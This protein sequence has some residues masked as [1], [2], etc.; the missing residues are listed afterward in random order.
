MIFDAPVLLALAPLVGLLVGGLAWLARRRRIRRA[1]AWSPELAEAALRTSRLGPVLLGGAALAATVALAGPRG[2]RTTVKAETRALSV[3]LAMDISRS[4]LAEDTRPSR[5]ARAVREARRLVQDLRDD[6]IGLV[7]FAGRSYILAPLTLDG[8]AITLFLD[9][10]SPDLASQGGTGLA[11]ALAQGAGVLN[12]SREAGD[13]VLV[14]FTDGEAHDSLAD[15]LAQARLV[16]AAGIRLVLVAEGGPRP[17]PIP[18]RD[19]TGAIAEYKTDERGAIVE[20][21]RRDD[22]LQAVADAA[23]AAL[24]P[25]ELP[26]QAG[27]VRDLLAA[28]Q[29]APST[30][31]ATSDLASLAWVPALAALG[32]LFAQTALRRT[33]ALVGLGA[34]LIAGPAGAQRP[35]LA[36]RRLQQGRVEE[37][38]ALLAAALA[39]RSSDTSYYNAGT[40]LLAA[41]RYPEAE[42]ALRRAAGSLDPD[43]RYRALYNLGVARL[44][45]ARRDSVRRDSL[46]AEAAASLKEALLLVPGSLRAKWNLEL[47][48]SRRPPPSGGGQQATPPPPQGQPAPDRTAGR[49]PPPVPSLSAAQAEEILNSV[50]REERETRVRRLGRP[51]AGAGGVKDW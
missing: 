49:P 3:V 21:R 42:A 19:S 40:A 16:R 25:S 5:L 37:A 2:G 50:G 44:E 31:T 1:A 26:D 4:M 12:A 10:L 46:L 27:A 33:A 41:A 34:L 20:T 23:E 29:R 43:L 13:R 22:V 36:E 32:L 47:A 7:A 28:Y 38:A 18:L 35:V 8:G 45:R 14:V 30:G 24:V 15:V 48:L 51:R 9:A 39:E 17:V 11:A 6:R